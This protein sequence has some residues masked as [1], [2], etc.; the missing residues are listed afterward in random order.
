MNEPLNDFQ[1]FEK[2]YRRAVME[3]RTTLEVTPELFD[4]L[5]EDKNSASLTWGKPGV[6]VFK[7]GTVTEILKQEEMRAEDTY[8]AAIHKKRH[9]MG[10][11]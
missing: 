3:K 9:D 10:L 6:R 7:T 1:D 2:A 5:C 4:Y 8:S 11:K